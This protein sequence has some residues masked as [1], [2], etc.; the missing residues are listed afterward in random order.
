LNED[1]IFKKLFEILESRK[2]ASSDESYTATLF[3][4]GL[5]KINSKIKEESDEVIDAAL[6]D[7]KAHLTYEI[8]DLLFHIFVLAA[9]KDITL[10]E[11]EAELERRFGKSGLQEKKER[12]GNK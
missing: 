12:T 9:H 10:S 11:I 6:E 2:S 3:S 5:T 1:N 8:C 7:D 4:K